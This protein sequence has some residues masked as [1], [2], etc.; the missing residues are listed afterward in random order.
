MAEKNGKPG[1]TSKQIRAI[2]AIAREQGISKERLEKHI[3]KKYGKESISDLTLQ[4]ASELIDCLRKVEEYQ[5]AKD[6]NGD[7]IKEV[8][9]WLTRIEEKMQAIEEK[10]TILETRYEKVLDRLISEV[11]LKQGLRLSMLEEQMRA[12]RAMLKE[13][14]KKEEETPK[15]AVC[16]QPLPQGD[17]RLGEKAEICFCSEECEKEWIKMQEEKEHEQK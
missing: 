17:Y 4:E 9:K 15:C 5:E 8:R 13:Y 1:V 12:L 7:G 3:K 14:F 11:E 2:Y 10:L 6:K 16:G